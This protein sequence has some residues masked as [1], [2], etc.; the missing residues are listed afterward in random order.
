MTPAFKAP[1][2]I[3]VGDENNDT[4]Y[5]GAEKTSIGFFG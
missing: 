1:Y 2:E 4:R 5:F 3:E